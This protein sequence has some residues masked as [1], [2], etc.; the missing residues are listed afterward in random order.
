[1]VD[2][3]H[4]TGDE[5]VTA[6]KPTY[7]GWERITREQMNAEVDLGYFQIVK[8]FARGMSGACDL[9]E[10]LYLWHRREAARL[11]GREEA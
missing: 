6:S 8:A 3:H 2:L 7:V 4:K 5:P 1:M 11:S 10:E 9:D